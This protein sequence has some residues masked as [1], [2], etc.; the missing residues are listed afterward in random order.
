MKII[1]DKNSLQNYCI[2][3]KQDKKKIGFVP[4]M[5]ALHKGH[6]SLVDIAK[7]HSDIVITSIFVNPAQ[8]AAHEDLDTY[9]RTEE[10]D[11]TALEKANTDIIYIPSIDDIY[12]QGFNLTLSTGALGQDLDGWIRPH[13]FDGVALVVTKLF[14][15]TQADVAVFGEKD[16]Q[17]LTIIKQLV[18][19]LDIPTQVIGGATIREA[20]GLAFASRNQYLEKHERKTAGQL[21]QQIK[22]CM[23][24]L[25]KGMSIKQAT[26]T[27]EKNLNELG[28]QKVDYIAIRDSNTLAE[29]VD[30]NANQ[31]YRILVAA[32]LGKTRLIDNM[33]Y[34]PQLS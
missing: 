9:P 20:D 12:P 5:G 6:T 11:I 22:H 10:N 1:R 13:F 18:K 14:M 32:I 31:E 2:Q 3:L 29:A 33:L 27:I 19:Q 28:F 25:N 7:Q 16:Y 21:N 4:T 26:E 30:I 23:A 34:Q 15:Q 8:F 17:Q 24:L